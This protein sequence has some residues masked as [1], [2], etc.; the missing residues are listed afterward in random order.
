LGFRV[1]PPELYPCQPH[2]R[3]YGVCFQKHECLQ[4]KSNLCSLI[5]FICWG[6][7]AAQSA[8]VHVRVWFKMR[9]LWRSQ[10]TYWQLWESPLTWAATNRPCTPCVHADGSI[11][12]ANAPAVPALF[13]P[14]CTERPVLFMCA[15]DR[16]GWVLHQCFWCFSWSQP[17]RA[18]AIPLPN[19]QLH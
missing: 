4:N 10:L 16:P 7:L 14:Y 18:P 1:G 15:T 12:A 13:C 19:G 2:T 17:F 8:L 11:D 3:I 5:E 6:V 9:P